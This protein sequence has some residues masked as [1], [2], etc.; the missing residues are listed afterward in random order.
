MRSLKETIL[1]RLILSKTSTELD[2]LDLIK[3][4][5]TKK[6]NYSRRKIGSIEHYTIKGYSTDKTRLPNMQNIFEM[7]GYD[8]TTMEITISKMEID[9]EI[10]FIFYKLNGG[11]IE[12]HPSFTLKFPLNTYASINDVLK[13]Y[14]NDIFDSSNSFRR[15]LHENKNNI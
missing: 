9:W 2:G 12:A 4:F 7:L 5:F 3:K 11:T 13:Q 15:F 10:M 14:I 8:F 1:E 6:T